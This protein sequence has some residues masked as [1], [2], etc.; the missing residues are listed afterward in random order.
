VLG[1][2]DGASG[3]AVLLE[4]ARSLNLDWSNRQIWLV[5]FDAED[6]GDLDGWDWIVGSR[7]FARLVDSQ[8]QAGTNFEAMILLDMVGDSDQQFY[9]E[10]NSDPALRGEIWSEA[11]GLG[12]AGEFHPEVRYSMIDD[13][14]PFLDL[15][16]P[17]VDIIDFDY[18]YW[19]TAQDTLDKLSPQ[20]LERIGRTLEAWL[21]QK[22]G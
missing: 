20:S 15:G 10:A 8:R 4:L 9:W 13:H 2:D 17:S 5:F 6:N 14:T 11:A 22:S 7:Q 19:H 1:A 21:E 16:L 12:Y 18:P 3:V